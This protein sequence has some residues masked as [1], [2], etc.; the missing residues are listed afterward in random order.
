M[1]HKMAVL[2]TTLGR[3]GYMSPSPPAP[4]FGTAG[5]KVSIPNDM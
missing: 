2:V 3:A 5:R 1:P 4:L